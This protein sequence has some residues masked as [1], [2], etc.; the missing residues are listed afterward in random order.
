[1]SENEVPPSGGEGAMAPSDIEI[2]IGD[3]S[4]NE[5]YRI[6]ANCGADCEPDPFDGGDGHG[7][8]VAFVCPVCGVHSV[9]DPFPNLR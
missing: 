1:M 4:G 2:R 7:L 5:N 8:R 9:V 6:C 3:G